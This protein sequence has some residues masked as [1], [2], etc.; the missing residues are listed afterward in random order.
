MRYNDGAEEEKKIARDVYGFQLT[1]DAGGT[2]VCGADTSVFTHAHSTTQRG[3]T[4][5]MR[6]RGRPLKGCS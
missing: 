6:A 1:V 4:P 5:V 3:L 2:G